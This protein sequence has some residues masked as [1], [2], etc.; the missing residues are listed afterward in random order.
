MFPTNLL[1]RVS[2]LFPFDINVRVR[3]ARRKGINKRHDGK[4]DSQHY[5]SAKI[6]KLK[7]SVKYS[8]TSE[9]SA[10]VLADPLARPDLANSSVIAVRELA[11]RYEDR[12]ALNGVSFDV[13]PA[14]KWCRGDRSSGG[15][16]ADL[17]GL[18]VGRVDVFA[19]DD[20]LDGQDFGWRGGRWCGL[21]GCHRGHLGVRGRPS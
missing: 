4:R 15:G 12:T 20:H 6:T 3:L 11:H 7:G 21:L 9:M 17:E 19:A 13:R 10:T 14:A 2:L 1:A 8:L 5:A 18:S 16:V